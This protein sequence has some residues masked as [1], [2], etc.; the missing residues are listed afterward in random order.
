MSV[1]SGSDDGRGGARGR[2]GRGRG[3][4]GAPEPPKH[5]LVVTRPVGQVKQGTSGSPIELYCNYLSFKKKAD[6]CVFKY[7]VDFKAT[8]PDFEMDT[9]IKKI[10]FYHLE[11]KMPAF[12]FDGTMCY[13]MDKLKDETMTTSWE[14][15]MKLKPTV[16]EIKLKV[17]GQV[18][19]TDN[20]YIHVS[21]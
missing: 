15:K 6:M 16:V 4:R 14:D 10:L 8:D 9:R 17:T 2:G 7:R 13:T 1:G 21:F 11:K 19:P 12:L 3:A 18:Y 5:D 20:D